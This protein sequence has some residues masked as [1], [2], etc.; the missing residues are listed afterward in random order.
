MIP[1]LACPFC[2]LMPEPDPSSGLYTH[3]INARHD[4]ECAAKADRIDMDAFLLA[5]RW[6]VDHAM[7]ES[8]GHHARIL[9]RI[10]R[11]VAG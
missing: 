4:S 5:V 11:R 6:Y 1:G 9:Y 7:P 3:S 8:A 10:G 2:G